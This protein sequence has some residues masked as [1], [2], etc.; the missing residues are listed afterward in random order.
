MVPKDI[1]PNLTA[2]NHRDTSLPDPGYNCVPWSAGDT[3][4]WWQPGEFW[5]IHT[6]PNDYSLGVLERAFYSIGYRDCGMNTSL[7]PGF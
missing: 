3:L 2:D 4:H 5:P 7:E 1:F 6:D